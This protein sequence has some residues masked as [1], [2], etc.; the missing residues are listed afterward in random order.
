MNSNWLIVIAVLRFILVPVLVLC[1]TPSPTNPIISSPLW[2]ALVLISLV[3]ITNGYFGTLGMQY[4]PT[5]VKDDDR[6]LTGKVC[7]HDNSLHLLF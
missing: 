2:V 6:E 5:M 7:S 1:V 3:G 4:P